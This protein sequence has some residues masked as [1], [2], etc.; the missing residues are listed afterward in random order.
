M[1]FLLLGKPSLLFKLLQMYNAL[2]LFINVHMHKYLQ[3]EM[4][5]HNIFH[6]A[7]KKLKS[8]KNIY[9]EFSTETK[10]CHVFQDKRSQVLMEYVSR[11]VFLST[12]IIV[13]CE[14]EKV[15]FSSVR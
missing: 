2:M 6:S 8:K 10:V 4:K 3:N 15:D 1:S 7:I 14:A 13:F 5:C 9:V 11:K 12:F